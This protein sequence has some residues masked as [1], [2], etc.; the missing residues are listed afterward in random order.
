[1]RL[2]VIILKSIPF[3]I[4]LEVI[5]TLFLIVGCI[6]MIY[7][8][9]WM[10]SSSF[11]S[12]SEMFMI[13]PT[14]IPHD[15]TLENYKIVLN[16]MSVLGNMYKNSIIVSGSITIIQ[17]FVCSAAA[18]VFAKM[19]FP[20]KNIIFALFMASMMVPAQL[21]VIPN[22]IIIKN[23]HLINSPV[24]LIL[25]G[26]F[27]AFGVFL[28]R[29]FFMT[30]PND[31][32]DAAKIDG[33]GHF[34]SYF[35]IH[36]PLAKSTIAVNSILCFNTAWGDFFNP[37]IF[38]K[39]IKNMTLPLGISLIQGV[40]S[41]QSPAVMVTTLVLSIIPVLIVFAFARERLIEGIAMT[42]I[43]L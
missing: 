27:S 15:P 5:L 41:Q 31:L 7:P 37:L 12:V 39:T 11:K 38:I 21:L 2:E 25:L 9:V 34:V 23:L 33:C 32:N 30:L 16:K 6:I 20:G 35:Y 29:Q 43:K 22:Y 8:F 10:I 4:F 18:Y 26:S 17:I 3:K 42:G 19:K 24:S 14:I 1:M 13:P 28:M 36:L 40:Y